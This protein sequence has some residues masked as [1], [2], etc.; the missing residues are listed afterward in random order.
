[1]LKIK[2][3]SLIAL[4]LP[5]WAAADIDYKLTKRQVFVQNSSTAPTGPAYFGLMATF[6]GPDGA[7][8]QVN[9]SGSGN[10]SPMTNSGAPGESVFDFVDNSYST[11]GG[12]DATWHNNAS[13]TFG[14]SGGTRG[15]G[16]HHVFFGAGSFAT[17]APVL[18]GNSWQDAQSLNPDSDLTLS[19]EAAIW[20]APT[21]Q[22]LIVVEVSNQH[23]YYE[24]YELDG[25][26]TQIVIP[27][28]TFDA[29]SQY[30]VQIHFI[31]IYGTD[32]GGPIEGANGYI[33]TLAF[34]L[35][36]IPEPSTVGLIAGALALGGTLVIRRR[37]HSRAA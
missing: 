13:Y 11:I 21:L 18:T 24:E 5:L 9:F 12:L 33:N 8:T 2:L 3:A 26:Q 28:N 14:Y 36:T 31:K 20:G 34:D 37:R 35:H 10:S 16:S 4:T 19:W 29:L 22:S 30:S 25:S 6:D 23:G 32:Q 1:M 15:T 7:F 27:N 17:S